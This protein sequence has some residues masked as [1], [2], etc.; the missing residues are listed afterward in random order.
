M[1]IHYLEIVTPDVDAVCELY[2]RLHGVTFGDADQS[3][4]GARTARYE[5]GG[6]IG[7]RA[8]MRETEQPVVRPY[9]LVKDI[10]A[11]VATA[12]DSGAVIALPPMEIAGHGKCAIIIQGGIQWG[13]WQV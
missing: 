1:M 10:E 2:S 3:L 6:S 7:I 4:G 9:I 13:L 5:E 8:P 12:A 11:S